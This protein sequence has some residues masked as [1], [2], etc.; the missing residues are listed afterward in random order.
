MTKWRGCQEFCVFADSPV[1][2]PLQRQDL[3]EARELLDQLLSLHRAKLREEARRLRLQRQQC[4]FLELQPVLDQDVD[5]FAY[6]FRRQVKQQVIQDRLVST[7]QER[8]VVQPLLHDTI[9]R[10]QRS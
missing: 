2:A 5:H 8:Y 4:L 10:A 1:E 7:L 6:L 9:V 3:L